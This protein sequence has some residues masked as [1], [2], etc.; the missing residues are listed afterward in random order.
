MK[1]TICYI[2]LLFIFGC[3]PF[4][5][6]FPA[7]QVEG[8]RPVYNST[9]AFDIRMIE[10]QPIE[11]AGKLY[12]YG[13][14]LLINEIEKGI[15]M[16]DNTNPAEPVKLAFI[17]V[18]G[19][20]DMVIKGDVI[21]ANNYN[22]LVAIKLVGNNQVEVTER[23]ENMMGTETSK[24]GTETPKLYPEEQGFY[25]ECVDPSKGE[26]IGW[27]KVLLNNPECYR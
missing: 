24:K 23:I 5:P 6:E 14:L 27:Q 2:L 20:H 19:S 21:Y 16:I 26:V 17:T 25:F 1:S 8:F 18:P 4:E 15:H 11:N 12:M 3:Q 13:D 9:Q 10:A 7:G 22:D